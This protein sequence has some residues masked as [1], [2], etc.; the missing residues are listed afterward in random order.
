MSSTNRGKNRAAFDF[1]ETP[2]KS[3]VDFL[4]A[5]TKESAILEPVLDPCSGNNPYSKALES[6]GITKIT[7]I[8]IRPDS[9]A[10]IIGDYLNMSLPIKY[11]TIIANPPFNLAEEF[12]NKSLINLNE[13][14][15]L[16]TLLRLNFFGSQGRKYLFDR[17]MPFK[18]YIHSERISFTREGTDSVEYMHCVWSREINKGYSEVKV[19]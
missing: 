19:I 3:I 12:I 14:G 17:I 13:G 11:N 1:Y 16:I 7:T 9:E 10:E 8:D 15:V 4:K 6:I 18:V 5:Y 2:V